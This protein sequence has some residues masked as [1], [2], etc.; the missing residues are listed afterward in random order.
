MRCGTVLEDIIGSG[1]GKTVEFK[2]DIPKDVM[3]YIPT[4]VA[5]SNTIGGTMI[6]GVSDSGEVTGIEEG[7]VKDRIEEIS[8]AIGSW[9]EPTVSYTADSYCIEGKHLIAVEVHRGPLTPYAMKGKGVFIRQGRN[10]FA[11]CDEKVKELELERV[12]RT[13]DSLPFYDDSGSR[14]VSEDDIDAV[15]RRMRESGD[16]GCSLQTL[17]SMGILNEIHGE[18]A[19]TVAFDLLTSNRGRYETSC[20]MFRGLSRIDFVDR[21]E[22]SGN[23]LEQIESAI[24]FVKRNMHLRAVIKGLYRE[25]VYEIPITAL[26]EAIVN[27]V[28]HRSYVSRD[29]VTVTILDDRIEVESPGSLLIRRE[30]LG[31]GMYRTR[32]EVLARYLRGIGVCEMRGTGIMRMREACLAQGLREPMV[33]EIEDHVRVTFFRDTGQDRIP[34]LGIQELRMLHMISENPDITHE[35]LAGGLGISK[36]YVAKLIRHSKD[37]G[38][39]ARDVSVRKGG[40][41]VDT[42]RLERM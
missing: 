30:Q 23:V 16:I 15:L 19:N 25:D 36:P 18:P 24:S 29:T 10:T 2:Q 3:R 37:R 26:R 39:L 31:T 7:L 1:E 11:A 21:L 9:I 13:F 35:Q 41:V 8:Y 12:N 20:A 5:F 22:C 33:E 28:V 40:W 38:L 17:L 42:E 32:N 14:E 34:A 6:F 4:V 27:A